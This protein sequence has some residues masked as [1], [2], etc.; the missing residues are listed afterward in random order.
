M[1]GAIAQE[2]FPNECRVL[3]VVPDTQYVYPIFKNGSTS[4]AKTGYPTVPHKHLASIENIEVYVRNP[5]ERFISGVQTYLSKLGPEIDKDTALFFV[6]KYLYLNR[7]F[8]PQ[9]FWL[10]N[11]Q[12]FTNATITINP[13]DQLG[14]ITSF[15]EHQSQ[16]DQKLVDFFEQKSKIRFYNE[17]DEVL[18][19]NLLGK[20][21]EFAE[22]ISVLKQNYNELYCDLFD[23]VRKINDVVS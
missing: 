20:T 4:L 9:L 22:I 2:L 6:E 21:V 5:H 12:R 1:L 14:E 13:L 19:I 17:V 7:H 15:K 11:L 10:I 3:E 16:R 18:T 8:C 23:T